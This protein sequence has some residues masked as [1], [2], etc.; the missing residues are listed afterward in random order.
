VPVQEL[1]VR[2]LAKPDKHPAIF[3]AYTSLTVGASFVLVINHDP[4]HLHD[5][6]DTDYPGSYEWTYL[7]RGPKEWRS[8]IGKRTATALLVLQPPEPRT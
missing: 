8:Q 2:S 1:D 4:K 6:F 7:E 5:E 3:A